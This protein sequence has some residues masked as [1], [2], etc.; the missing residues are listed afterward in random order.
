M[1]DFLADLE[2]FNVYLH[3]QMKGNAELSVERV[4]NTEMYESLLYIQEN[5]QVILYSET[6]NLLQKC[7]TLASTY[8]AAR[9]NVEISDEIFIK[10]NQL[11]RNTAH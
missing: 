6:F 9:D 10:L 4:K 8:Q 2:T 7:E 1:D 5:I 11:E 3:T